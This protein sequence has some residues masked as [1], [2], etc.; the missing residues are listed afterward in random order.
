MKDDLGTRIKKNYENRTRY[1]LP[2]RTYTIIRLDIRSGHNYCE[3]L[4]RPFDDGLIEDLN[5]TVV[6]V[7]KDM[8]GFV[9]AYL[10]SDEISIL[11][12][13]FGASNTEA[14]FDGNIQKMA[15]VSASMVTAE[16]N[17]LRLL[18]QMTD[19][20][21]VNV[22]SF[23]FACFDSRVFTIP[24]R[25]EVYNYFIWRWKDYSRN[26][27]TMV[28]NAYFSHQELDGKSISQRHDMLMSKGINWSA[29]REDYKNG[30]FVCNT[31]LNILKVISAWKLSQVNDDGENV[32]L[33]MIWKHI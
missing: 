5:Q 29:M 32:F 33:S 21:V 11:L 15:S 20:G 14:W 17:R 1:Y 16:F 3:N 30:R 27:V 10:Q 23:P 26:S 13:D 19:A 8:S 6:K 7:V 18:R 24:D 9:F 25:V 28:A 4:K 22:T 31:S 2:R 12:V